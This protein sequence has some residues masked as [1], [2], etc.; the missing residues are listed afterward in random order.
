MVSSSLDMD[1]EEL[2]ATLERLRVAYAD[3]PEYVTLRAALPRDW[4]L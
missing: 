1:L 4:P 2:L 3:D